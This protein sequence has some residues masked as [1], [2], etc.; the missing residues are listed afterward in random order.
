[1]EKDTVMA[2]VTII[3]P[4]KERERLGVREAP[5]EDLEDLG[6][7]MV[8]KGGLMVPREEWEVV[9]AKEVMAITMGKDTAMETAM[10]TTPRQKR[11]VRVPMED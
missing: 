10:I 8:P 7:L 11:G 4:R 3:T 9:L 2:T 1:M 5:R 6:D